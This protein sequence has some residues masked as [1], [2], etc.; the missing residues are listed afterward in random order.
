MGDENPICTL[1]DYSKPS[2]DGYRNTIELLEG[3]N[4]VPLRSDTIRI[5]KLR[6]DILM[7][8]QHLEESLSKAWTRFKD[9]LQKVPHHGIDLWLQVQIFYDRANLVTRCPE[10]IRPSSHQRL[11]EAHLAPK[12]P[13][14]V[15]K[16]S[17]SC[18]IYSG[19]YDT[20]YCVENL[21]KAF[22]DYASS[23][24]DEAGGNPIAQMDFA[25]T[26]H[27]TKEELRS[28]GIKSPSK[29]TLLEISQSTLAEPN[30]NPSS[31]KRVHFNN[32]IIILNKEVEAEGEGS[33]KPSA[34]E[35]KDHEI[36]IKVEEVEEESEEEFKEETEDETK[37]E[38]EKYDPKYFDTFPTMEELGYHEWLLKNP[39]PPWVKA[40]IST[41]DLNNV[42]FSC[43]IG[44]FDKK[45]AYLDIES[46]I[47]VM[48]RLN[49]NWI[50]S[51]RLKSR[52]K[53][54]NPKKNSNFV[55]RIKG[56]KYFVGNFT[57]ECDFM[58]LEDTT[59][60]IHH[61]LGSVVFGKPFVEM[62]RL[63]YDKKEGS[64]LFEKDKEKI[65]FKMP[66]KMKMFKHI[67]FTNI[68]TDCIP[69][70]V[71]KS[72]EDDYD[73]TQYS[74]SL[75]LRPEYKYDESVCKAILSLMNIKA[76][77]NKEEVT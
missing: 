65:M 48:S 35:C 54:S 72:D 47:N 57:Y 14:Q 28:K 75:N 33:M 69:P 60:V 8:Q 23:R 4:V 73:K 32:L 52:R 68:K 3:N 27:P 37:E 17:S 9:L 31:P 44:H 5:V 46:P 49:Y 21:K 66:Y 41:E 18:E 63:V 15:N 74:D 61:Y 62:T 10:Y 16:I 24:I 12:Q 76:I 40:K 34:T 11:M 13:I 64:V 7:F 2:H 29:V 45:Q 70:F 43:M 39:R 36:T 25:S 20:Q 19:P 77:R 6:N 30:R 56:L 50:M 53:P 22:V 42:K 58:V 71:I 59:S 67:D 51:N 55:G 1:R 38:K 26:D